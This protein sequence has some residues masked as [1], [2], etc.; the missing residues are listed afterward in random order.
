MYDKLRSASPVLQANDAMGP[1][2]VWLITGYAEARQALTHPGIS[3]DTRR[4][5]HL[6]SQGGEARDINPT[7]AC[8]VTGISARWGGF[9]LGGPL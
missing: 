1:L 4:F 5:Q 8:P 3:K 6:L 7:V 9:E 2:P